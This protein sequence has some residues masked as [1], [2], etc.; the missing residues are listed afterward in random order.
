MFSISYAY[1]E[2]PK[3]LLSFIESFEFCSSRWEFVLS[4]LDSVP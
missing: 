3:T 4:F 2:K 1:F